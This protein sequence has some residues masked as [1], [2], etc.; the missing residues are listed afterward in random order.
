MNNFFDNFGYRGSVVSEGSHGA[1]LNLGPGKPVFL[2]SRQTG[3]EPGLSRAV[4]ALVRLTSALSALGADRSAAD[5]VTRL[6]VVKLLRTVMRSASAVILLGQLWL[7]RDRHVKLGGELHGHAA[8]EGCG[9]VNQ[10][11]LELT[12]EGIG[13]S[14]E[15]AHS[16]GNPTSFEARDGRLGAADEVSKPLLGQ[17]R[18]QA[19]LSEV[20]AHSF[21]GLGWFT[22]TRHIAYG[23]IPSTVWQAFGDRHD[24]QP[25][26]LRPPNLDDKLEHR[27]ARSLAYRVLYR[28]QRRDA[29]RA[30]PSED[31]KVDVELGQIDQVLEAF[32]RM[33]AG[34]ENGTV[35][36]VCQGP[37]VH[38]G[39]TPSQME[40]LH[41]SDVPSWYRPIRA[42]V[43]SARR[44]RWLLRAIA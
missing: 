14:S 35:N 12:S 39:P 41:G 24:D 44:S 18:S 6:A 4:L 40:P 36:K 43:E 28:V 20:R 31:W 42:V 7:L 10:G 9:P 15:R 8:A 13:D 38:A 25:L 3:L 32:H 29:L 5:H 1:R 33:L 30:H 17:T 22:S 34:D 16:D 21:C 23:I 37:S 19:A 26:A 11:N 27:L 2:G